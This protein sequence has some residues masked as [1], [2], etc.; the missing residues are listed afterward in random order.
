MLGHKALGAP[1]VRTN[2]LFT[3]RAQNLATDQKI[4]K[5]KKPF[6]FSDFRIERRDP[7]LFSRMDSIIEVLR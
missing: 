7:G 4:R 6:Q 3:Q 1:V 5:M 2:C